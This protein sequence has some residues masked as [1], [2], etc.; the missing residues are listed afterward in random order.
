M[1]GNMTNKR[2]GIAISAALIAACGAVISAG[3]GNK[4]DDVT[5]GATAPVKT[6]ANI[7]A[8]ASQAAAG[9]QQQAQKASQDASANAAAYRAARDKAGK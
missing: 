8:D 2:M 9:Q 3:C 6:S 1:K 4:A 7:P 5:A